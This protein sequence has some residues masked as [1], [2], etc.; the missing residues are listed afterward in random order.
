[1]NRTLS[2]AAL[3]LVFT[4]CGFAQQTVYL[5]QIVNGIE[6]GPATQWRTTIFIGNQT[7]V[8]ASGSISLVNSDGTR[9]QAEFTDEFGIAVAAN[10]Q[11]P[12][13]LGPRQ[14]HKY[15]STATSPL[16]VG[17]AVVSSNIPVAANALL[18][19]FLTAGPELLTAEAGEPGST[20]MGNQAIFVDTQLGFREGIAIVNP[21]NT[22]QNINLTLVDSTGRIVK[23]TNQALGPQGHSSFFVSELFPDVVSTVGRLEVLANAPLV[24]L[25]LRFSPNLSNF[26]TLFPFPFQTGAVITARFE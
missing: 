21:S 9:M 18:S 5:P 22:V 10:G 19:H 2:C 7:G 12:F 3:I 1:M 25:G 16:Q 24:T 15:T 8:I 6:N 11:V 13:Q 17:Y 20:P 4:V 14:T 23:T 26:T